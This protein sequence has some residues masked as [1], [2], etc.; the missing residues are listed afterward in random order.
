MPAALPSQLSISILLI[1]SV[2]IVSIA[3]WA[4]A[5]LRSALVLS[6]FVIREKGHVHRLLTAGWVH[7]DVTHLAFNMLTLHFFAN[8]VARVLGPFRFLLLYVT[9]VI[10]AF[11]PTTLRH[12]RNPRYVSLGASG[13]VA[14]VIFSAI[15]LRPGLR[16]SLLFLPIPVSGFVYGLGYLAYSA[17]HSYRGRGGINHDAHFSGAIYG[18]LLTFAFEPERAMTT[19]RTFF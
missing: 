18:M 19:V 10:A 14:A 4:I 16:L 1:A 5:P 9:A 17:W 6:P 8:E 15:L 12:M 3:A 2:V 11:V 13:A 7:A